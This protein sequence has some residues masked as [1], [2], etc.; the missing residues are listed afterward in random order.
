MTPTFGGVT[1]AASSRLASL[2]AHSATEAAPTPVSLYVHVPFCLSKCAYCDFTSEPLGGAPLSC[3]RVDGLR[4]GRVELDRVDAYLDAV[5][6]TMEWAAPALLTDVPTVYFGGGTPTALGDR[7]VDLVT[8]VRE[9]AGVRADAE[10]TV[11]TNPETTH[12]GLIEAL[13]DSGVTRFSLGVQSFDDDVLAILGRCHDS[14]AAARACAVLAARDRPFSID[15]MCGIPGQGMASWSETLERAA[16]TGALHA[17]VYA[18]SVE[19]GTPLARRI[20]AGE[21]Q[22]PDADAAAAMMELAACSMGYHAMARYE[23]ANYAYPGYESRHNIG[24]W[25]GVPYIGIGPSAASMLPVSLARLLQPSSV[26]EALLADAPD[27]GRVRFTVNDS[28]E[29]FALG[30]WDRMPAEFEVL[31]A[32]EAAREDVMLG[33]RLARGVSATAV[34]AAGLD[35]VLE[36]LAADGLVERTGPGREPGVDGPYGGA[37]DAGADADTAR[38]RTTERGWLLGNEV[39]AAVWCDG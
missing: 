39:F 34:R 8:R 15:L 38:W 31:T 10:V 25:T 7:L 1:P 9:R 2:A 3:L 17:S 20:E 5:A 35:A 37:D 19:P 11:E 28:L 22:A 33:L 14:A 24:Y 18:L 26:W 4:G 29:D 36:R 32:A 6:S 21:T 12:A 23:V 30:G 27:D 13:S 16:Q